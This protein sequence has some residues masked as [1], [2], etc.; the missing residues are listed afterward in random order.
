MAELAYREVC[1]T[2][3]SQARGRLIQTYRETHNLSETARQ[4][5]TS[6]YY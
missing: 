1:T 4:W 2:N 6:D 3:P 5:H